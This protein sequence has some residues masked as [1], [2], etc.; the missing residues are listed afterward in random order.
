MEFAGTACA[1]PA[2]SAGSVESSVAGGAPESDAGLAESERASGAWGW[3]GSAEAPASTCGVSGA[4]WAVLR[5]AA[6]AGGALECRGGDAEAG[7]SGGAGRG[8]RGRNCSKSL[9]PPVRAFGGAAR[10]ASAMPPSGTA[11]DRG[12]LKAGIRGRC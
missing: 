2:G 11:D 9:S 4:A 5:R 8:G 7:S 12:W 6:S 1:T 10:R 3:V